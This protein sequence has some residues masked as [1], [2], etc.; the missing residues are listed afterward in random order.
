MK[1]KNQFVE[2]QAEEI[3][4]IKEIQAEDEEEAEWNE[5]WEQFEY[6]KKI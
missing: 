2:I 3:K 1:Q 5:Q 6:Y 4:L